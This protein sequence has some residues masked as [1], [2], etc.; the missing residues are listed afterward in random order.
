MTRVDAYIKENQKKLISSK[1]DRLPYTG[2][3]PSLTDWAEEKRYLPDGTTEFPGPFRRST[4]P[5]M[6]EIL[7][8]LHPDDPCTHISVMKS[9]QST[10]TVTIA[11]NAMG[12]WID[13]KLG[14][15]LFLTSSKGIGQ[16]RSSANIDV[17]ID[18][19]NL[20]IKPMSQRM[21]RKTGDTSLYKEFAGNIK[22]LISSYNS[23]GDLKSNTF[24]LIICDEW[25]EAGAELKGQGDIAGIIQG[26]TH[27]LHGGY[28]IAE[29][30]TP[31][32]MESSRIYKSFKL[33][34]QRYY[35]V[36]CPHC[37]ELQ[38]LELKSA[39]MDYGLAFS[40][41]TDKETGT[42]YMIQDS[43]RYICK[44]CKKTFKESKKQWMLENGVW[45]PTVKPINPLRVS[46]HVSGLMSP[47]M[48]MSWNRVCQNFIDT[49]FG[50]DVL[51]FKDFT[52]NT[53]GNPWASVRKTMPWQELKDRADEY[54]Y[55]YP[56]QGNVKTVDGIE[57]Y[58]DAPLILFG[59]VDVQ[60]DRLELHVVGFGIGME[61]WSVDYQIFYGDT[62]DLSD[63]SWIGLEE[64]V[65]TQTYKIAGED[66]VIDTVCVDAGYDP[67]SGKRHKDWT[68]KS[69]LVYEFVGSH[70]DRFVAIMG[71]EESKMSALVKEAR[72]NN[73]I[74]TKRYNIAVG[75]Y[76]EMIMGYINLTGG[77]K[78][79]H[80]PK[81]TM[82]GD[83][84]I[85]VKDDHFRQFLSERW[86]EIEP[87][88]YGWKLIY[89]RNEVLDTWIYARAAAELRNV[90][91]WTPDRWALYYHE[92]INNT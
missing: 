50:E 34:D 1:I 55:G 37:G 30:S 76:K 29:I 15:I 80:F 53:L 5:H 24:H 84:Q 47:E 40:V 68:E 17:M 28:K 42:K 6:V 13:H 58:H 27:G 10:A 26:R 18:N 31:S 60:G 66:V 73:S 48:F 61:S 85:E 39:N 25:D 65:Y 52:I 36:P 16:I 79:I 78:A 71:V 21:K 75:L 23:I 22:L 32:R 77:P 7:E 82:A 57:S 12:A 41:E 20:V 8:R 4:A 54:C 74:L 38:I 67:R 45:K 90:Q 14:S 91:V 33:G 88:K 63:S 89:K 3:I 70:I 9:V 92:L 81:Y 69:S 49:G 72:V 46:Y 44:Y 59:G 87:K 11:E 35:Y 2:F 83:T 62:S 86:E 43:V 19:A 56:P 51:A 64:F